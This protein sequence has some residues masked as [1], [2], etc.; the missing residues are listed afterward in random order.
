M[1]RPKVWITRLIPEKGLDLVRDFAD[2]EVWEDELPPPREVILEKVQGKDGLLP[3]LTDK[4]DAE[5]M[6]AAGPQLKVIS[7]YAVGYDN[8][9]VPTATKR[10][11]MVTNTPG[12]L[13]DT[14]A[15]LAWALLMAAARRIVEGDKYVR[16]GKWK[17]WGPRLMLGQDVHHATLGIIG[18]GRIGSA[19]AKRARGFAMRILYYDPEP[20]EELA[21]EVGAELV[22]LDTLLAESDFITVHT[23]LTGETRHLLDAEAFRKMKRTAIVVN[24]ARGP[25]INT[26]DLYAA[27]KNGEILAAGLDV[28]DPEP[29]PPEHPLLTL[30]NVVIVPHVGSASVQTRTRMATMAAENLIAALRG[31]RPPNLVNPEVLSCL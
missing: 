16:A 14:T 20:R 3:L 19:V 9:D 28:T 7:N 5:V 29:I 26:E 10:G 23:P 13:T 8:I 1:S 27:L 17:T 2:T 30:D 21:R 18:L 12:V 22:D 25:I 15:D 4:I 11:I 31:E 6:D 24:S